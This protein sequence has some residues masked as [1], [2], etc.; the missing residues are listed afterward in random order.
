MYA[1]PHRVI[2]GFSGLKKEMVTSVQDSKWYVVCVRATLPDVVG[3][4]EQAYG[5]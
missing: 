1:L 4:A 5:F 2:Q 3:S